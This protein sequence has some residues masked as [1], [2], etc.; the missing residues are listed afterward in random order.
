VTI[1]SRHNASDCVAVVALKT[2][3]EIVINQTIENILSRVCLDW[4]LDNWI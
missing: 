4:V 2:S 1:Q 3:F